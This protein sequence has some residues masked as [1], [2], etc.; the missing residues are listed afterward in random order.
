MIIHRPTGYEGLRRRISWRHDVRDQ[1]VDRPHGIGDRPL[2]HC[3]VMTIPELFENRFGKRVALARGAFVVLGG[4]N[5]R[6][7]RRAVVPRYPPGCRR[8]GSSG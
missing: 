5:G 4:L 1:V 7:L 8:T 6:F 3:G 2:A